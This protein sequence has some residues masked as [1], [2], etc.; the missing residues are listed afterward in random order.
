MV[1]VTAGINGIWEEFAGPLKKFILKRVSNE[2]D[3]EDILQDVFC[4]ICSNIDELKD[5]GKLRAWVYQLA[6][7]AIIDYYRSRKFPV[8]LLESPENLAVQSLAGED[9]VREVAQC[10]KSMINHLPE[11]YRQAIILTEFEGLSQKELSAR[12]GL[13]F[14]GAKSRV[15]RA[16]KKLKEMLLDC[17]RFEFDHLGDICDYYPKENIYCNCTGNPPRD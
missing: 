1:R 14:S 17:C 2:Y 5:E 13:S 6:R 9:I 7:N 3:A 11:K 8:Q 12:L 10:L 15:Q 4:K 16:R